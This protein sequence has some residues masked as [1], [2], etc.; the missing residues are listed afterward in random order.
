[1]FLCTSVDIDGDLFWKRDKPTVSKASHDHGSAPA[2]LGPEP[3]L[4]RSLGGIQG[5]F[6]VGLGEK[7]MDVLGFLQSRDHYNEAINY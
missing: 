1:M 7:P 4:V 6:P 5:N 3:A 2:V